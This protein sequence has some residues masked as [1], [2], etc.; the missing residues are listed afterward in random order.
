M[1]DTNLSTETTTEAAP[2]AAASRRR[3]RHGRRRLR[4][5][6][7]GHRHA[8]QR[9]RRRGGAARRRRPRAGHQRRRP[10]AHL[11]HHRGRAVPRRHRHDPDQRRL[12]AHRRHRGPDRPGARRDWCPRT[13]STG[14]GCRRGARTRSPTTAAS[15]C[16][17]SAST[18]DRWPAPAVRPLLT[19]HRSRCR[20]PSGPAPAVLSW[21]PVAAG[22]PRPARRAALVNVPPPAHGVGRLCP[23][24]R[25]S[26]HF[27]F[28]AA[29]G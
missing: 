15:S 23:R 9:R 18:S 10:R 6:R 8:A 19:A 5:R 14:S 26:F 29:G 25:S 12:P 22:N 24:G 13:G 28:P 17:P 16:G 4:V 27:L 3:C 11:R 2:T 20:S 21:G 1:T 7:G